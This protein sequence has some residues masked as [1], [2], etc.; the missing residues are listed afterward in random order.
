[1]KLTSYEG[2][3]RG[4]SKI[5]AIHPARLKSIPPTRL[6]I[7]ARTLAE[8]HNK[9]FFPV[10]DD[11]ANLLI[12]MINAGRLARPPMRLPNREPAQR[13]RGNSGT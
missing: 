13:T 8:W 2:L 3:R 7:D 1:M 12:S 11:K 9:G 6:G 5:E 4:A 10:A